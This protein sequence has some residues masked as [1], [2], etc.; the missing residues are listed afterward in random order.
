MKNLSGNIV[1]NMYVLVDRIV[2][3]FLTLIFDLVC[4]PVLMFVC[5][6]VQISERC[7]LLCWLWRS[8]GDLTGRRKGQSYT[9]ITIVHYNCTCVWMCGCMCACVSLYLQ[10][11]YINIVWMSIYPRFY[12]QRNNIRIL[13]LDFYFVVFHLNFFFHR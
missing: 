5:T 7:E 9:V 13:I 2:V 3:G 4:A 12:S 1:I 6:C 10:K 8:M 11:K